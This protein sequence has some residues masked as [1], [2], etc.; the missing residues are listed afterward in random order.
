MLLSP[1]ARSNLLLPHAH[2][3]ALLISSPSAVMEATGFASQKLAREFTMSSD[4]DGRMIM[5]KAYATYNTPYGKVF[6]GVQ[7]P[8]CVLTYTCGGKPGGS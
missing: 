8:D 5:T 6:A 4:D 7:V 3:R 2:T 1:P